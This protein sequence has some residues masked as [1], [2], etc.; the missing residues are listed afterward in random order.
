MF[1][2]TTNHIQKRGVNLVYLLLIFMQ[3]FCCYR[4][5]K[6]FVTWE[7]YSGDPKGTKYS[8]LDQIN[9]SNVSQLEP[10]WT[11]AVDVRESPPSTIQCNPIVIGET[12]YITSPGF[13][14]I[15]LD[16]STGKELWVYQPDKLGGGLRVSRGIT[17]WSN[18]ED[19]RLFFVVGSF[20]HCLNPNNGALIR[21]FGDDGKINLKQGLGRE[22]S[23]ISVSATTPGIIYRDL[24]ILGSALGEG[25]TPAAP[26]HIRAFDVRSGQQVWIFHTIPYPT[27]YGFETWSENSWKTTGGTNSWGGFTLDLERGMVFCGTGSPTYDHWGGDR[28]GANLFGNCILALDAATGKRIWHYQVVHHDI[29]DYDIPCQPNLVSLIK[30]GK[31]IDA[32]A[33]ATKMGHLFVL[34]RDT[35]EPIFPIEELPVPQSNIPGEES[36]PT[37]PFPP[38][39][40]R[41][42][43]Q[44]FTVE[45]VTNISPE[46]KANVL[47][48]IKDMRLGSIFMPPGQTPSAM[49]PQF[50]GGTDWGGAAF[51][52]ETHN[53]I[54][55]SS[56][57]LEWISMVKSKPNTELSEYRFGRDLHGALCT[58]CHFEGSGVPSLRSLKD[59]EPA[60]TQARVTQ[61]VTEGKDA[62]PS[63]NTLS[64][65]EKQAIVSFLWDEGHETKVDTSRENFTVSNYAPYVATGHNEIKDHE[66]FPANAPPWGTLTSIDLNAGAINW[67]V[68]LGT[69][70]ELEARG[71][72]PTGTF[73]M[74]GPLV[75]KGGL[76]FIG[77]SMDERFHA[78]D[79]QTGALLWEYQME[80]G[81]YA[82]PATYEVDGRQFIVIA[83]GGAGKPGTK[84]G[85]KFYCFALPE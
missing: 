83:A 51:D 4:P 25:P 42:A 65:V 19:S 9:H 69:Y 28:I 72:P 52:P 20:L 82:T 8:A 14:L 76:V 48:Q 30:D 44:S 32:V 1:A 3:F 59:R 15:A 74:G 45:D 68:P 66:G 71:F 34:D 80:A 55:N 13:D 47:D 33:Q 23:S 17:Y 67:Q 41:Y 75:T 73:N 26:G 21:S 43:K 78:Y 64:A 62:M 77:A 24:L 38:K 81:G 22:V 2:V 39:S 35:G 63:F 10:A 61:I 5:K 18:E 57:E 37:Q 11:Y 85:D 40:L 31:K 54:V 6:E 50:N 36:Y 60:F 29:W 79:K 53:L 56:N 70:P 16:A 7:V 27:E 84:P 46:A 58:W 12:M 49:L